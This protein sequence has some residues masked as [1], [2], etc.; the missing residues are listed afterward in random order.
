M[1]D[2]NI[3]GDNRRHVL[4]LIVKA[5]DQQVTELGHARDYYYCGEEKQR[6]I[7]LNKL[8]ANARKQV[9]KIN[10]LQKKIQDLKKQ[11]AV[12]LPIAQQ[13]LGDQGQFYQE[14]LRGT[15]DLILVVRETAAM[16]RERDQGNLKARKE[17]KE[18]LQDLKNRVLFAAAKGEDIS[19]FVLE[20]QKLGIAV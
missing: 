8:T 5:I 12:L 17:K 6:K 18:K 19:G 15:D 20:L 4:D 11:V 1:I 2:I 3:V 9:E 10:E 13:A 14:R 16:A 7:P